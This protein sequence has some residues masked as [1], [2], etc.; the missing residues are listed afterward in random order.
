MYLSIGIDVVSLIRIKKIYEQ[1]G[2]KFLKKVGINEKNLKIEEIAGYFAAKEAGFKALR[3]VKEFFNPKEIEI[4]KKKGGAP[5]LIYR[6]K[7]K[8]RWGLVGRPQILISITHEKDFAIAIV[9]LEKKSNKMRFLKC[10]KK[11][12]KLKSFS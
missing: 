3:P 2:D 6:G 12:S 9:A 4:I 5:L 7:L 11:R 10:R 1:F 8:K